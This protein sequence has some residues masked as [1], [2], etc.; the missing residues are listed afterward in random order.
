MKSISHC[1]AVVGLVVM[2]ASPG[3]AK[4]STTVA[5][6]K[7]APV[8]LY[9]RN[10]TGIEH[11][12]QSR[13]QPLWG[14]KYWHIVSGLEGDSP[15]FASLC[16]LDPAL[17]NVHK[18]GEKSL[19]MTEK[20]KRAAKATIDLGWRELLLC[21]E[22]SYEA[23]RQ[24]DGHVVVFPR[25]IIEEIDGTRWVACL[26]VVNYVFAPRMIDAP[27]SQTGPKLFLRKLS[28]ASP[29]SECFARIKG[30]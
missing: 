14:L 18:S 15:L 20:C 8:P 23:P 3:L 27:G 22:Q 12:L 6:P 29:P 16:R 1:L 24:W 26:Y 5:T 30:V 25:A 7:S 17:L 2:M 9:L 21:Y 13:W 10:R 28:K 4:P 19:V 11:F